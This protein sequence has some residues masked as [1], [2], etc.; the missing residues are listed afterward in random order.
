[1]S[2][3]LVILLE[4]ED[5]EPHVQISYS[6]EFDRFMQ[7]HILNAQLY[8]LRPV[9]GDAL[10]VDMVKNRNDANYLRLLDG[11]EYTYNNVTYFFQGIKKAL[12]HYSYARYALRSG[13]T[14]TATGLVVKT[15]EFSQPLDEKAVAR[16][17]EYHRNLAVAALN[18][19]VDFIVR[20]K[21]DYPLYYS[22][23]CDDRGTAARGKIRMSSVGRI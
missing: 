16:E 5:F 7:P 9:L 21:S 15:T 23:N 10:Y 2:D 6:G 19:C 1:M 20:N 14:D 11:D 12:V 18:D 8:D 4:K 3:Q 22:A 17:S 13:A